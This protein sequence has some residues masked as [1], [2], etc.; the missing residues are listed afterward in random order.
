MAVDQHAKPRTA[1]N[2]TCVL[3]DSID[4][5]EAFCRNAVTAH[6][7]VSCEILDHQGRLNPLLMTITAAHAGDDDDTRGWIGRNRAWFIAVLLAI[8]IPLFVYDWIHQGTLVLAVLGIN[9]IAAALRLFFWNSSAK[10]AG[11]ERLALLAQHRGSR[12]RRALITTFVTTPLM[13]L[14]V[15]EPVRTKPD[16]PSFRPLRSWQ[17]VC[18]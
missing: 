3:F 9:S 6:L 13:D 7:D 14:A 11:R 15:R 12:A 1:A 8:A 4:S 10:R 17:S 18:L 5:A 16:M 2:A